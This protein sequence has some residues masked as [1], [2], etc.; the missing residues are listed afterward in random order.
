[1]DQAKPQGSAGAFLGTQDQD[2]ASLF[3]SILIESPEAALF[4]D[5]LAAPLVIDANSNGQPLLSIVKIE[6]PEANPFYFAGA[7]T[8]RENLGTVVYYSQILLESS[9]SEPDQGL[10]IMIET[11]LTPPQNIHHI[12]NPEV[13][14]FSVTWAWADAINPVGAC[15]TIWLKDVTGGADYYSLDSSC[16]LSFTMDQ[17]YNTNPLS[18]NT[19]YFIKIEATHPLYQNS[20]LSDPASAYTSANAPQQ[21]PQGV[22]FS[23][24]QIDWSWVSGGAEAGFFTQIKEDPLI[25]SGWL[26]N[27]VLDWTATG[28]DCG[29]PYTLQVKAKNAD[30]ETCMNTQCSGDFADFTCAQNSCSGDLAPNDATD[31]IESAQVSTLACNTA[32]TAIITQ[33]QAGDVETLF[34]FTGETSFDDYTATA[35]LEARW[36]FEYDGQIPNWDIDYGSK[37]APDEVFYQYLKRGAYTVALQVRDGAG[38]DSTLAT[39]LIFAPGPWIVITSNSINFG[40]VQPQNTKQESVLV[41]NLGELDLIVSDL[42]FAN[43]TPVGDYF[44]LVDTPK[45]FTLNPDPAM[46]MDCDVSVN[47]LSRRLITIEFNPQGT[48]GSFA[49]DLNIENTDELETIDLTGVSQESPV[50]DSAAENVIYDGRVIANPPP[51]FVE[52]L[53]QLQFSQKEKP[54]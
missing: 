15:Y 49:A 34:K 17:D 38:L 50:G 41:C 1:M 3:S 12:N 21:D 8:W 32:P 53:E 46:P 51:G 33:T 31:W 26:A 36:D 2:G 54:R 16:S 28:L 48:S 35:D 37:L 14:V 5:W 20:E 30:Y 44:T 27:T 42:V 43:Q 22:P 23:K 47:D 52:F 13:P 29:T 4:A 40:I 11:Q 6:S 10:T 45:A 7:P 25:N 24:T 19:E 9:E 39:F 18:A